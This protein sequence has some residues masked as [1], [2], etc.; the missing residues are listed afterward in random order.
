MSCVSAP[1]AQIRPQYTRPHRIVET[2]VMIASRYHAR[3]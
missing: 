1:N 3:L 2:M